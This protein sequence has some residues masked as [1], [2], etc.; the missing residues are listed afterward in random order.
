MEDSSD[1]FFFDNVINTSLD[2]SDNDREIM[3]AMVLL[4]N[5]HEHSQ[6]QMYK[7]S[8][9]RK[10]V[11]LDHNRETGHAQLWRDYFHRTKPLFKAPL[12][13]QC[14]WMLRKLFLCILH[15][16]CDYDDYFCLKKDAT[17]KLG[18]TSYKNAL[19]L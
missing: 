8:L 19:R 17:V 9:P 11:A 16:V 15:G 18:F 5:K 1:E 2:D 6:M 12:F 3:M 14:F 10:S 4:I 13:L 7:G